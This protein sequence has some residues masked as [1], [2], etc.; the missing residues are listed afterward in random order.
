[1]DELGSAGETAAEDAAFEVHTLGDLY[2]RGSEA[3]DA[4]EYESWVDARDPEDLATLIYTSGTTG[5]PKG[6][7]LSHWNFRSNINQCYKRFGPRPDREGMPGIDENSRSVS[8]LPLAHVLERLAGH[9]LMFASGASVAY[10]ESPDT[11]QEDF[12]QVEPTT[13]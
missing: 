3:F 7:K 2:E 6:V 11:L 5:K 4:D 8:F 9:F 10:A 1:M 12:Q 13:G